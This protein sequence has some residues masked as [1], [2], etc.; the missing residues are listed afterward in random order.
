VGEKEAGE[1]LMAKVR[2]KTLPT[3]REALWDGGCGLETSH[4]L[5]SEDSSMST[6]KGNM[7]F[8]Y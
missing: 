7:P 1:T 8:Y 5:L 4:W 3:G 2:H 6:A